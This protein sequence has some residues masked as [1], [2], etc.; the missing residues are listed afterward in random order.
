MGRKLAFFQIIKNF[1]HYFFLD[2]FYNERLYY[3]LYT[4][5][6]SSSPQITHFSVGVA[7]KWKKFE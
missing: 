7:K 5:N 1:G 2:M 4:D 6:L 3:L